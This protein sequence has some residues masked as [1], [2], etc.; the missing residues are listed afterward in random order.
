MTRYIPAVSRAPLLIC[1]HG[2]S[3]AVIFILEGREDQEID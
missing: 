3:F 1:G 2:R